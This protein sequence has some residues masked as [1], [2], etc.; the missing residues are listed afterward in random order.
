MRCT[1]KKDKKQSDRI[2]RRCRK[3]GKAMCLAYISLA[4]VL[5]TGCADTIYEIPYES[6]AEITSFNIIARKKP[7]T[8]DAFASK[9]CIVTEDIMDDESVDMSGAGA[10]ILCDVNS[11]EV[12]YAKN[13]HSRLQPASLTKIMTAL[14]A[15]KHSSVEQVLTATNAVNITESGAQLCGLKSGDTMTLNQALHVLLINSANDV[16]M[17]IAENVGGSVDGFVELMNEEAKALGATNTNFMNPHGLTQE[18][19]YTTAYDLYLIFNE[20]VQ[21][22]FLQEIIRTMEYQTT[23]YDKAGLE[24]KLSV[25][26]TN[27]F[28]R[29]YQAPDHV[30]VVGGKTGTT[31][32]AGHCLMLLTRDV[33]GA[34]YISVILRSQSSDVLYPE[35]IDL[36]NEINK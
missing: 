8:A 17:L 36:L 5:L 27:R 33:N 1:D 34:P 15:L 11:K 20:A 14:V 24:K 9:L 3:Q 31:N 4:C 22:E 2:S 10:A 6:D 35:M 25:K 30:T 7:G 18:N 28:F 21:N 32:A 19:H 26:N 12:L 23:Y 16:A 13:A 29:D